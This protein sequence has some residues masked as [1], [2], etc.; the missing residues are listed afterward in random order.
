[1]GFS[2]AKPIGR[3]CLRK[4]LNR[5]VRSRTLGGVRGRESS[6]PSYS[7]L[8]RGAQETFRKNPAHL[9][10]K[11]ELSE[12]LRKNPAHLSRKTEPSEQLGKKPAHLSRKTEL[13]E[14]LKKKPAH[15][16]E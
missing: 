7:I 3:V 16:Y 13:S 15:S 8:R 6:T 10:G 9:S 11:T 4:V 5:P 2:A 12:Q 1:M 14:Q